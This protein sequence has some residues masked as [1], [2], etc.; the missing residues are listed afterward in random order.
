MTC[1]AGVAPNKMLAKMCSEL[2]K[3]NGCTYLAFDEQKILEFMK[4]RKVR[5]IPGVGSV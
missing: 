3:P 1:S 2:D 4:Q 5:D